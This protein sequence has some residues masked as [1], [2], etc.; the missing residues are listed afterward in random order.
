MQGDIER[1]FQYEHTND[2][3]AASDKLQALLD[4]AQSGSADTSRAKALISRIY[5]DVCSHLD[6]LKNQSAKGRGA[7]FRDWLRAVPT[8]IAAVIAIRECINWCSFTTSAKPVRIQDLTRSIGKLYELEA[9]IIAAERVNPLYMRKIHDQIKEN[10]T[11][12]RDHIRAVYNV[13]IQRVFKGEIE[14]SLTAAEIVQLGKFG[15]DACYEAGLV[16]QYRGTCKSGVSVFF[17][18]NPDV[19]DFLTSYTSLDVRG[20]IH[21]EESRM[22]CPPDDWTTLADGGYL[23]L[24]RKAAAPLMSL[25]GIRQKE[26]E[27]IAAEFTAEKMPIVFDTANYLQSRAMCIHEP[28]RRAMLNVWQS[29]GGILG[30]PSKN[31]PKSPEMP[32]SADWVK[33]DAPAHE[34]EVFNN[35]KRAR[36][37]HF[38]NMRTWRGRSREVGAFFRASK[39]AGVPV[40]FPVYMDTRG[41]WYYRGMPNPQGSDLSKAVLHFHKRKPL[42]TDGL[43]WLKVHIA[44]SAG[45][46]KERFI[47]RARWTE[48]NWE[49][50]ERALDAP[51]DYPDVWGNDAPW[52]MFS[53][54]WELREAYRSG[55][56]TSYCTGIPVHMDA[57]CSGLQHF[58]AMLRDPVGGAYVNL[59]D[60]AK[61]G[62]KQDIYSRVAGSAMKAIHR[63]LED[64]DADVREM[65]AWWIKVG[66]PRG[67]A[68]HPV[69]TYVYGATLKGTADTIEDYL[70]DEM[71]VVLPDDGKC[72]PFKYCQYA[73]RK[74]FYGIAATVPAAAAAMHWLK[75]VV[76]Q[77]PNGKRMEWRTPTGFLV[78]HDY[79]ADIICRVSIR[80]CGMQQT[81]VRD[82]TDDTKVTEM[83][84]AISP[85]FVHALDA[86][87]LT[88]T[89]IAMR[90]SGL[91]MVAIHDSFGTH[92]CDV[93]V[94]HEHIRKAFV[95][96]YAK[97]NVLANFLWDVGGEAELPLRGTLALAD[98]IDSE[99]FFC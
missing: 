79:R 88:F 70:I 21:K 3:Q 42:G 99:F 50:I 65:A 55:E 91:D 34:V 6:A 30:V 22:Y 29:G 48:Q 12:S 46:D 89:A 14:M 17:E 10:Y 95:D 1:Q 68:K 36:V 57:T 59:S 19:K 8:P 66:F 37:R 96:M 87:H 28:T 18:L 40:W 31:P 9:R 24:R 71:G 81:L 69:M 63:D 56:P 62:P 74:L 92:A 26:R 15:L 80:S 73:A 75:D 43:F 23:T 16:E 49:A 44:N 97:H 86:S 47:D 85:N 84:N 52:C 33:A 51:A 4:E 20:V 90:D 83:C 77:M 98:V 11:K 35:W 94:M 38:K 39:D 13:A 7:M 78:Q 2:L 25:R 58:S 64:S 82:F 45:F 76:R 41:R 72:S 93:P 27:R 60:E 67:L 5:G 32:F 54:A 61:C 53:A